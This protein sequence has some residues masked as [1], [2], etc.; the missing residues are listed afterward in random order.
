MV[1][2][3]RARQLT[4]RTNAK[5]L[6]QSG[7]YVFV[8][9][10]KTPLIPRFNKIDTQL[11]KDERAQA[12]EEYEARHGEEPI[13]VGATRDPQVIKKMF[14]RYPNAVTSIACGPSKLAVIDAD[15]K[16]NG[17]ELIGKHF[18]E[19]GLP[20]TTVMIPTQS[21]GLHYIFKDASGTFTNSAGALKRRYG[22]DVRGVGGQ[23]IA[24]GSIREDGKTYGGQKDLIRFLRAYT[25]GILPP[26]PA[27]IV[28]LIGSA[29]EASQSVDDKALAAAIKE[30]EDTDWPDHV[31]LYEPGIG[32]YDLEALRESNPEYAELY[33]NPSSDCSDNRWKLA[34][35]V[36]EEFKMPVVHLAVLY[37]GWE[38]AGTQTEDGK[39][40][41]NYSLRD[42]GREWEKNKDR[43]KSKG[44]ALGAVVDEDDAEEAA[45][46]AYDKIIEE[47]RRAER[48]ARKAEREAAEKPQPS[49]L[50]DLAK[51]AYLE[52]IREGEARLLDWC[53][54]FFI[55]RGTTSIISGKWGSGKTAV[56]TDVA[57]HIAHGLPYRGRKV[58]KGVVV[59][60]ALEN[61][62]DVERRVRTWC[63]EM[64]KAGHDISDGAFVIHRG[65]CC[66][67]QQNS[68]ATPDEKELIK[69]AKDA[70]KHYGLPVSMIVVDTLSQAISP[71]ND[72]EH[73][74]IFTASLQRIAN[75][76]GAHS[77][78]LHHPTKQG[79]AVRGD[80]ALQGNVD[81]IIEIGRDG[82]GR[83]LV[84]AGS[85]F[86][87][88]DPA[89]VKFGYR[90]Q[91]FEIGRD[92]DDDAITVVLAVDDRSTGEVMGPVTD[93]DDPATED[94]LAPITAEHEND[95]RLRKCEKIVDLMRQHGTRTKDGIPQI[96]I[97]LIASL[98][99]EL[100][101]MKAEKKKD[102]A[103][104]LKDAYFH[105]EPEE[106]IAG[107]TL[108][109][110]RGARGE[111]ATLQF[112][113]GR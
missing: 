108:R 31:D 78:S 2:N 84:T 16:D 90:L 101:A 105:G 9:S 92:E 113:A 44:E 53:I 19:H 73:G 57:L 35:H 54:K 85:K 17:P 112:I 86:R 95:L 75:A 102:F 29:G 6:A 64:A 43:F 20:E 55:A 103:Q 13:H 38:G 11:T 10:G 39:G 34:Q 96:K 48:E 81:T 5:L 110:V 14:N 15:K 60:V 47:R 8:S 59:Y 45:L 25:Q 104:A 74:S 97:A 66:L 100:A 27:H 62:E 36:L 99:P 58:K 61:A 72:R 106:N 26:V 33:D 82:K 41:G 42:I 80:S 91:A 46:A 37:E 21:G 76:T 107:G 98:I 79:E 89:K 7:L 93:P 40:S 87:I 63:D 49:A 83:G 56:Y 30:L 23:Y 4:N 18:E 70:S 3:T 67:Y 71:G 51:S 65:P 1:D 111:S 28:D 52:E 69:I 109:Y 68:K 94:K 22:C 88:G 24:P 32:I 12:V 77:A 50:P